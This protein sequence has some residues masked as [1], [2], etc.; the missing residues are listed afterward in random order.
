MADINIIILTVGREYKHSEQGTIKKHDISQ[1]KPYEKRALLRGASALK[2]NKENKR[3]ERTGESRTN[4]FLSSGPD[5]A[6]PN[7]DIGPEHIVVLRPSIR[8]GP[9]VTTEWPG[10][11]SPLPH[12]L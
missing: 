5:P 8:E 7:T 1:E 12:C 9:Q 11:P 10:T 6:G 2:F 3:V 4:V